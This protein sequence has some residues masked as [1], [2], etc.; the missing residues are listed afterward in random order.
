L[1]RAPWPAI[2]ADSWAKMATGYIYTYHKNFKKD[3]LWCIWYNTF[4]HISILFMDHP[5]FVARND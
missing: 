4:V 2:V 5:I 3:T 1:K